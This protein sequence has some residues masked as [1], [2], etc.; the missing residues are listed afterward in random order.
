MS[1]LREAVAA[2]DD[3]LELVLRSPVDW[4]P[5]LPMQIAWLSHDGPEPG[6]LRL[7]NR[8]GK[9][10]AGAA[11]L[12][13]RCRGDHPF[14]SVP[15]APVRCALVCMSMAQS[16][17][18]QLVL[19]E[20]LGGQLSRDVID[21]TE[22]SARTGFRGHRPVVEF[23]N[24]S[25]IVVYSNAQGAGAIAGSEYDYI[26]L[27]EP[28]EQIVY[29]EC[30]QRVTQTG[31]SVGLT[32]T[33]I[34]GPPLPWLQRLVESGGVVEYH[35]KL[36][37]ESQISPLTGRSRK[38]KAGRPWDAEFIAELRAKTNPIDEPIRIDGA[39]ESR[40]EGQFFRCFDPDAHMSTQAPPGQLRLCLGI[41][42]AAADREL[43]MAAVLTAVRLDE[44]DSRQVREIHVLAEV[45]MPGSASMDDFS[46]SIL[47]MLRDLDIA[48]HELD[49]IYGDNPVRT[50]FIVSSNA[51][52][53]RWIA[54]HLGVS[55]K[56][57]R[58]RVLAMKRGGSQSNQIRRTKDV[59][60][61]WL[62]GRIANDQFRVHPRCVT[63][64]AA[65]LSWD[66]GDKHPL[67]DVLDATMYGLR[68]FWVG[69]DGADG[70][71]RVIFG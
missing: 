51:E 71:Q 59:R 68:D 61:R 37:P 40:S 54:R 4:I 47:R 13:F 65:L 56:A 6:L 10:T 50:R 67:K 17:A 60:C 43:G 69:S 1:E 33:P 24:G 26:L 70:L 34:N 27:D 63:V 57:L 36:T 29:D 20:C 30:L 25:Q 62:W 2:V 48:W 11:E 5:W 44:K 49:H 9:S 18:I 58:P 23:T 22:F 7:G 12:I 46:A 28:P 41:D 38:T 64:R 66:Y 45:L 39:W 53:N 3:V 32:L 16:V 35:T 19:W 21:G 14:K 42:Y 55:Q 52:V 31:G 15:P 8:Q